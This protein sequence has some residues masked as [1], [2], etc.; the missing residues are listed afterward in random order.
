[1]I[2]Y[3]LMSLFRLFVLQEK[4]KK[5]TRSTLRYRTL[6]LVHILKGQAIRSN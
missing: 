4:T 1:M 5:K 3:D 2:A 6:L